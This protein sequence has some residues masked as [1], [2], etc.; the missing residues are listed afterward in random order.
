[1][2]LFGKKKVTVGSPVLQFVRHGPRVAVY[3]CTDPTAFVGQ[4]PFHIQ[5]LRDLE[6]IESK[7]VGKQL[8]DALNAANHDTAIYYQRGG[9]MARTQ[10][11]GQYE[12]V[13]AYHNSAANSRAGVDPYG[14]R[15][16]DNNAR[17]YATFADEFA[18]AIQAYV[19]GKVALAKA[20]LKATLYSWQGNA[21]PNPMCGTKVKLSEQRTYVEGKIDLWLAGTTL[22]SFDQADLLV[23]VMEPYL[24][25]GGG[26]RV[27]VYYDPALSAGRPAHVG[28][29]HELVHSYYTVYGKQLGVEDSSSELSG[30]R[31]F[32]LMSVGLP[33]YQNRPFSENKY[34]Q[35]VACPARGSYP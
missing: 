23:Q 4:D 25:A 10:P 20:L 28:L 16:S 29:V 18:I 6:T 24:R 7:A 19:G 11:A 30:G 1:M 22:P 3:P 14:E 35:A 27:R 31:H 2:G 12:L 32:E 15:V 33:P 26:G 17:W 8:L 13:W 34:R 5:V 9:N 21:L